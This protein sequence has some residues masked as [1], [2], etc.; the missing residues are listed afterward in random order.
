M[1]V[2]T[3]IMYVC[4]YVHLYVCL[5]DYKKVVELDPSCRQVREKLPGLER[6]VAERMEKLK[7]E[8][9]GM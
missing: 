6:A 8:T 2:C 3:Y 4:M 5:I 7:T 9:L 1:Y